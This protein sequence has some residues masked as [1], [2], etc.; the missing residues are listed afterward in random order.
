M[1]YY[2]NFSL[3]FEPEEP[4]LVEYLEEA[5]DQNYFQDANFFHAWTRNL[6]PTKWYSYEDD[7]KSLSKKF[8][9]VLFKLYGNGEEDDDIWVAYAKDGVFETHRP[10]IVYP[11]PSFE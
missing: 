10:I 3:D 2:T 4:E 9:N 7:L 1:G 11:P 5:A 6:E 8:P